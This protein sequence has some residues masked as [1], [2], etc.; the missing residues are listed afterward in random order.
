MKIPRPTTVS[1]R[2][3]DEDARRI[4]A[5]QAKLGHRAFSDTF[6]W[7][8]EILEVTSPAVLSGIEADT[9]VT[10]I[11]AEVVV[12]PQPVTPVAFSSPMI[13]IDC[14]DF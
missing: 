11:P 8:L 5:L 10:K 13:S 6:H 12:A 4:E 2:L 1:R 14:D 9:P 7:L 3:Q